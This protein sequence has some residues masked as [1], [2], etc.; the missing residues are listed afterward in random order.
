MERAYRKVIIEYPQV[1]VGK[2][3]GSREKSYIPLKLN[4]SG[5]LPPIFAATLIGFFKMLGNV[6]WL[7]ISRYNFSGYTKTVMVFLSKA[8]SLLLSDG[9][10]LGI[11]CH[12]LLIV[13]FCFFYTSIVF[14]TEETSENLRKSG[15]FI[16]GYRP[17]LMTKTHLDDILARITIVGAFYIAFISTLPALL[18][19]FFHLNFPFQGTS[20]LISVSITLDII[21]HVHS[22]VISHQYKPAFSRR[23]TR[24]GRNR[25]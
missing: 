21:S 22:Y 9:N 19:V 20:I 16:P 25:N 6:S 10:T 2:N 18:N 7:D 1:R 13:L 11:L 14:N 8:L 17:G 5:V 3:L 15:A 24:R 4:P 12:S 23:A